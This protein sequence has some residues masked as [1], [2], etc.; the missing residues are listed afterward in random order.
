MSEEPL[1]VTEAGRRMGISTLE[2]LTLAYER[3][4]RYVMRRGI[5]HVPPEAIDE[6]RS[7]AG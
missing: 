7:R 6:Y 3:K 2:V 1:R 5:V 4:L